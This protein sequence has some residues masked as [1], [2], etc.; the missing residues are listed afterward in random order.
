MGSSSGKLSPIVETLPEVLFVSKSRSCK[1]EDNKF[2][3][4]SAS[5]PIFFANR[6]NC[7]NLVNILY[8]SIV[9]CREGVITMPSWA[10]LSLVCL[11]IHPQTWSS[12]V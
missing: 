4:T 5:T 9:W 3:V 11:L 8:N 2:I 1:D 7:S 10:S 12:V 6:W